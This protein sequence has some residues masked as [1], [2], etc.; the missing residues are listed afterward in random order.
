MITK[1]ELA[2]WLEHETTRR[3][4]QAIRNQDAERQRQILAQFWAQGRLSEEWEAHRKEVAA[5]L[6][7]LDC[8]LDPEASAEA[9]REWLSG[10]DGAPEAEEI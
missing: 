9:F 1:D 8:I 10:P 7:I 3:V 2:E 6:Q 4:F 5:R